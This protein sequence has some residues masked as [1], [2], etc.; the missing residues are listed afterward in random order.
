MADKVKKIFPRL[1]FL[2]C[3]C[4]VVEILCNIKVMTLDKKES[5]EHIITEAVSEKEGF[6]KKEEGYELK[7]ST[8]TIKWELN[9]R[10]VDK[11]IYYFKS[12]KE[13]TMCW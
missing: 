7:E 2:I 4:L 5:G 8:G 12:T 10:Y 11:F 6:E 13:K 9:D 1:I 3:V